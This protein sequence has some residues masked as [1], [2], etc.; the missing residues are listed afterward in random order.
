MLPAVALPAV[1]LS[2]MAL[3]S[4]LPSRLSA[5]SSSAAASADRA[6]S[7]PAAQSRTV[8]KE[9]PSQLTTPSQTTAPPQPTTTQGK[10]DTQPAWR[11]QPSASNE[12]QIDPIL[13][14]I[15]IQRIPETA[16]SVRASFP[17]SL[18]ELRPPPIDVPALEPSK[19]YRVGVGD[20]LQI[21]VWREPEVSASSVVVRSDGKISLPLIKEVPVL[22]L[23]PSDLE[24]KLTDAFARFIHEP[25][26]T[27]IVIEILSEKVYVVGGVAN[28]GSVRLASPMTVLQVLAEAGGLTE[29][30]KRNK[31]H[32]LRTEGDQRLR[33]PFRYQD[34]MDGRAQEQNVPVRPGD[35]IVVPQ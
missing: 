9:S 20:V 34:V 24:R 33:L 5:Q 14:P 28:P 21:N 31:I 2:A 17:E 18:K 29:F 12:K 25:D 6:V 16:P 30:A 26:V 23:T 8:Q 11:S 15:A 3:L 4:S 19:T 7:A 1:L 35:T 32:V 22:G 27:V 13:A 10:R